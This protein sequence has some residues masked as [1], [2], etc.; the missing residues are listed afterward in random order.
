MVAIHWQA[1]HLWLKGAGY[2]DK[3]EQREKRTTL[4]SPDKKTAGAS[5]DL[6]KRA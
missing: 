5:E 2:R 6:R 3:P 1:F 4:A